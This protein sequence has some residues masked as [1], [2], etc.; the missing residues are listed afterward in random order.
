VHRR[1]A[2]LA[3][4]IT[5]ALPWSAASGQGNTEMTIILPPAAA[6]A[7]SGPSIATANVLNSKT[8]E[9]LLNGFP[10]ALHYRLE[11]WR[12][13]RWFDD[14]ESASE[15]DVYV[16]FDVV[17]QQ[18]QVLRQHGKQRENFGSFGSLTSAE[19]AVDRAYRVTLMPTHHGARYYYAASLV[20]QT[21]TES[22][23]DALQRWL[24]GDFEPAVHGRNNP[25]TAI[26]NGIGTLLSRILGGDKR[27]YERR[28][29]TFRAE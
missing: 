25:A 7:D 26:G 11:L 12:V 8:R 10:A 29:G 16:I 19:A 2:A 17:R 6:L 27:T 4:M 15:W 9:L 5:F 18:Y 13:G 1:L 22:D 3:A 28:S 23:L 20:V 24:R 14:L 21:L